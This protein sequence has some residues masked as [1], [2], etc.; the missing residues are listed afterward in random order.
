MNNV[1]LTPRNVKFSFQT[2][3]TVC[4]YI[5]PGFDLEPLWRMS[6]LCDTFFYV[7][8]FYSL[9]EV[10]KSI[11]EQLAISK[12]LKLDS[13]EIDESFDE[14]TH[15]DLDSN[16]QSHLRRAYTL[17]NQEEQ[18]DYNA[19]FTPALRKSQWCISIGLTRIGTGKKIKLFY[20][21]GEGL[22]SYVALSK[23]GRYAPRVL[24]TIQSGVL[25]RPNGI[26]TRLLSSFPEKPLMWVRGFEKAFNFEDFSDAFSKDNLYSQI[27]MDF[28]NDWIVPASYFASISEVKSKRFCKGFIT[29]STFVDLNKQIMIEINGHYVHWAG[30]ENIKWDSSKR[31]AL[32]IS[33]SVYER[34]S[35]NLSHC[36]D[37]SFW[38]DCIPLYSKRTTVIDCIRFLHQIDSLKKYDVIHFLPIG[39]EDEGELYNNFLKDNCNSTIHLYL[40]RPLDFFELRSS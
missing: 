36:T 10:E 11:R 28:S 29:E 26:M 14:I 27:G 17:L 22:A 20:F 31:S 15:F 18:N 8:L 3:S 16:F 33:K 25:E 32:F 19:N 1:D 2:D 4:F 5:G 34:I 23:N 39:L 38:E 12:H 35:A 13:F 6:N 9:E 37:V 40:S 30:I 24:C 21:T 7:N